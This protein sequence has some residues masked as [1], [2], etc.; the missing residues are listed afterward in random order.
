MEVSVASLYKDEDDNKAKDVEVPVDVD[1]DGC[2]NGQKKKCP[3]I[4]PACKCLPTDVEV[5]VA[6]PY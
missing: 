3:G 1:G 2:P 4:S 5:P 6:S